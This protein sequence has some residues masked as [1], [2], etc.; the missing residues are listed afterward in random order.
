MSRKAAPL[1]FL[2]EVPPWQSSWQNF[3]LKFPRT[4]K[5]IQF[6]WGG[7][8]GNANNFISASRCRAICSKAK[9][10]ANPV[11]AA[12]QESP[13]VK[14]SWDFLGQILGRKCCLSIGRRG[15]RQLVTWNQRQGLATRDS[16]GKLKTKCFPQ[17]LLQVVLQPGQMSE[18]SAPA[19]S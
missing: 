18:V 7:C 19:Q 14:V 17:L 5:C 13:L 12:L 8:G 6:P 2:A 10:Q 11:P 9:A 16:P 4:G 3:L 1:L 15:I